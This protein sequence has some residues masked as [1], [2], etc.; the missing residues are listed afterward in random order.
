MLEPEVEVMCEINDVD[1]VEGLLEECSQEFEQLLRE[2]TKMEPYRIK[3]SVDRENFL[4]ES[5]Q[6][7]FNNLSNNHSLVEE[8]ICSILMLQ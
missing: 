6:Y 4:D 5:A 3:L 1:M 2:K 7:L 8:F